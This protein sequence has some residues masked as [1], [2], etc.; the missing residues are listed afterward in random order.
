MF[1]NKDENGRLCRKR[2]RGKQYL[3]ENDIY[4]FQTITN[5]KEYLG[6]STQKQEKFL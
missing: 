1:R 5:S 3:D 6:Y 4:S 2:R